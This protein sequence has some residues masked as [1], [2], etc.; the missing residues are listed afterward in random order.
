MLMAGKFLTDKTLLVV[1]NK[2]Q[3]LLWSQTNKNKFFSI[4]IN[5]L[6]IFAFSALTLLVGQQEEHPVHKKLSDAVLA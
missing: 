4:I 1:F 5:Y 3:S 6:T 2:Y